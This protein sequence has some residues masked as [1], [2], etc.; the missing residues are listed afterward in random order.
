MNNF[1]GKPVGLIG[2]AETGPVLKAS[3]LHDLVPAV[4]GV[5]RNE[6]RR[7]APSGSGVLGLSAD[8]FKAVQVQFLV[9]RPL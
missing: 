4:F 1:D 5:W 9:P 7:V 8:D 2:E 3:S 6:T